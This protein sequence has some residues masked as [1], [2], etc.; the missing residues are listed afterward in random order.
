MSYLIA[1]C[2]I[3]R[4]SGLSSSNGG[5]KAAVYRFRISFFLK[6]IW[7]TNLYQ[8]DFLE[9]VWSLV[10]VAV[11][12]DFASWQ[13]RIRLYCQGKDNDENILKSI[14]KEPFK[15]GKFR[16]TLAKGEEGALYLGPMG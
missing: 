1:V 15:M 11:W 2:Q 8:F 12:S 4:D 13:Q 7:E 14:D 16:E 10:F 3:D 5:L 9:A 6:A